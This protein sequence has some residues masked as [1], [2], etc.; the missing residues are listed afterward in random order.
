[1]KAVTQDEIDG[2]IHTNVDTRVVPIVKATLVG[3]DVTEGSNTATPEEFARDNTFLNS[4]ALVAPYDPQSLCM[5]LEKS[6]SLR[7][8]IDAYVT[9][10]DGF[11]HRLEPE[12]NLEADDAAEQLRNAIFA[13]RLHTAG[14]EGEDA[15][16]VAIPTDEEVAE[17]TASLRDDMRR[18]KMRLDAFFNFCCGDSSFTALRRRTRQDLELM[19][20]GFWEILRTVGGEIAQLVYVPGFTIRLL[21]FSD[22]DIAE[23]VPVRVQVAPLT[24]VEEKRRVR[25]R[26]YVQIFEGRTVY[27][28]E[29]GDP[30]LMSARHGTIHESVEEL[31]E[32]DENDKPATEILHFLIPSPR[33]SYGVPRWVGALLSV[34]GSRQSEEVNFLYF[35][36]KSIPPLAITVSGGRMTEEAANRIGDYIENEIKGKRNF[37]KILVLEADSEASGNSGQVK[38]DIK[39]LTDAQLNDALFQKYDA[40]NMDKVGMAFRLPRMLRGDIRDFNRS[41]AEAAL[42]FAE[43]QVFQPEREDF[44][45]IMNRKILDSLGAQYWKFASNGPITRDPGKLADIV[46]QLLRAGGMTPADAR[47]EI[48][49]ILNR[50]LPKIDAFWVDQPLA[51]TAAG[52]VPEGAEG[53]IVD[54]DSAT[55]FAGGEVET[56]TSESDVEQ[57]AAGLVGELKQLVLDEGA[58]GRLSATQRM[59]FRRLPP[60]V[61]RD[62]LQEAAKLVELRNAMRDAE[63]DVAF[64]QFSNAKSATEEQ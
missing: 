12:I 15:A 29:F 1:M 50:E 10:I 2:V 13:E 33:S 54:A 16:A 58:D 21:P 24:I 40:N 5:L 35:E 28:K 41:T 59:T 9:N 55:S 57:R 17:R 23:D 20:N 18:E 14:A 56:T 32:A 52:F 3:D 31:L 30:R 25:F 45:W 51:V 4:G 6:N 60:A 19:G 64:Q 48:E 44:D 7:Q 37:H 36:N 46:G 42:E 47:P 22:G 8:N 26:R 43:M 63:R 11:G 62:V 53:T 49:K 39:P 61:K 38:I 27:F 34:L